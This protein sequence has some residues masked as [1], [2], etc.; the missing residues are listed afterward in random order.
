MADLLVR[1]ARV[2][3]LLA[4]AAT[5]ADA[6]SR[7]GQQL[8]Q[9]L[10]ETTALSRPGI[11]LGL[12]RCLET[13]A[14]AQQMG[15]LLN[16][17][18]VAPAAHVLL[19]GNVFVAALRAIAIATASSAR[20][21][22]RTSRRDPSMAR[23]LHALVPDAFTLVPELRPS[24]GDHVWAYGSDDTLAWVRAALPRGVWFHPH[25]HGIG[26]AVIEPSATADLAGAV[27]AVALDT[28][29]FDQ[30]GCLSPR[31]LC[32]V[33]TLDQARSVTQALASALITVEHEVPP[34]PRSPEEMAEARRARDTAT[35]AFETFDAG[36]GWLSLGAQIVVPPPSRSLHIVG[37][38]EPLLMLGSLARSITCIG[39][40]VS[41]ALHREL[42]RC[43]SGARLVGLG[44]MQEP[45]L[46][47]PVDRRHSPLGELL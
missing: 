10:L 32:V 45:E 37:A 23:A 15:A 34:G 43:F 14:S 8:R 13:R 42:G 29:L 41:A 5:L 24:A 30:R 3:R 46:D 35:Y 12:A 4:A 25:G 47:G 22:V 33:G 38:T 20:V 6:S 31:V 2:E 9:S 18:P 26:V 7:E 11:E 36:S 39:A 16:S 44:H 17:T 1:S 28:A 21:F 27:R 19:S 40:S